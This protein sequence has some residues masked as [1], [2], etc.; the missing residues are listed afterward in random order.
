MSRYWLSH[1]LRAFITCV[2]YH[3]LLKM[4]LPHNWNHFKD[5]VVITSHADHQTQ[6]VC[7]QFHV[8]CFTTDVFYADGADFNKYAAVEQAL[9]RY[10]RSGWLC[11]MDADV[12]FPTE[13][14]EF[15]LNANCLYTPER[16]M[17]FTIDTI[18]VEWESYHLDQN[19]AEWCGY[20]HIFNGS[21]EWL[22]QAPWYPTNWKHAGGA[23]TEFQNRFPKHCKIRP[24]FE[25]LHMGIPRQNWCGRTTPFANGE[26][27]PESA[28]RGRRMQQHL[29]GRR[30]IPRFSG[31]DRYADEKI[32]RT[33][34]SSES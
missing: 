34:S 7:R 31:I 9:T 30:S 14:P 10:G 19:S 15:P 26:T 21:S 28:H 27:P 24:P 29:Q 2:D 6:G 32:T 22:Q 11:V 33:P 25:C 16:R 23:D 13:I 3:D 8:E 4:T 18:P 17:C 1:H 5:I 12:A 20:A